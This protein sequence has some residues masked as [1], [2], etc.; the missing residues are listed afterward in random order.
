MEK[1]VSSIK[2]V[3]KEAGVSTATV[4]RVLSNTSYV[5]DEVRKRVMDAVTRMDYRPNRVARSLRVQKSNII[6][7]IVADIQNPFF[8][9]VSRSVQD[10]AYKNRY[11]I[12]L[13]NTDEQVDKEEE[14]LN[15]MQDEH[16]AGIIISPTHQDEKTVQRIKSEHFPAVVI[17]REIEN[18]DF[19][20]VVIDNREAGMRLINHIIQTGRK[21]IA[22]LVGSGSTTGRLRFEGYK[23]ALMQNNMLYNDTLVSFVDARESAGYEEAGRI[24]SSYPDIDAIV[25]TN[26]LLAAGVYRK[27]RELGINIPGQVSFAC[28]DDTLWTPMVSPPV[29]VI[30][31]PTLEMGRSAVDLLLRRIKEGDSFPVSKIMLSSEL[32]VR[33]STAGYL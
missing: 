21:K 11:N 26:G 8:T 6:G 19:D 7:L 29:T 10:E 1:S 18:G 15:I 32:V 20:T 22:I 4:S 33:E 12:F 24:V 2:D 17:D 25:A 23:L 28:F 3:A 27:L 14:Y 5:S 9:L 30:K 31:Q 13:C 16:V